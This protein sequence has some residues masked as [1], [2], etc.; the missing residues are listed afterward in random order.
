MIDI[1]DER[2]EM[3]K[4]LHA[5][6]R[7]EMLDELYAEAQEQAAKEAYEAEF[8]GCEPPM[9]FEEFFAAWRKRVSTLPAPPPVDEDDDIPF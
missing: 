6:A 4:E 7:A 2:I 1:D 5:D 9:S 8:E 3:L